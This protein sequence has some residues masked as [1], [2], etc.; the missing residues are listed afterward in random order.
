M[1]DGYLIADKLRSIDG[2]V[3]EHTMGARPCES[4]I[5][6]YSFSHMTTH[7][8]NRLSTD[9]SVNIFNN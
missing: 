8:W 6:K 9:R 2:P 5:R 3:S 1:H 7:E 4:T